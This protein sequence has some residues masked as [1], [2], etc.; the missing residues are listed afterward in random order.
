MSFCNV[1]LLLY[2]LYIFTSLRDVEKEGI[3]LFTNIDIIW[4]WVM[5]RRD[6]E[7][8][9]CKAGFMFAYIHYGCLCVCVCVVRR[10]R[11]Y[12]PDCAHNNW[13]AQIPIYIERAKSISLM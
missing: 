11:V 10:L 3:K 9:T 7:F 12:H 6:L 4:S 5:V 2:I 13:I 8:T 1:L